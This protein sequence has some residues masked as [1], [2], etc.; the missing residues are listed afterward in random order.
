[1]EDD[2]HLG[3]YPERRMLEVNDQDEVTF[4]NGTERILEQTKQP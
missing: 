3:E 4:Y 1:M 2:H